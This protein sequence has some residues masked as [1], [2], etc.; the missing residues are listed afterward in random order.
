LRISHRLNK[1][2][3]VAAVLTA[4]ALL[5]PAATTTANAMPP[6]CEMDQITNYYATADKTLLVGQ[7]DTNDF[8][9]TFTDWGQTTPYVTL[10]YRYC[11][12]PG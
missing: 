1:S 8:C 9:A 5:A 12:P 7:Y 11:T 6:C 10:T 3:A 4:G 2:V